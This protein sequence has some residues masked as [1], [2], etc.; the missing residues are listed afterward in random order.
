MPASVL[1]EM[2]SKEKIWEKQKNEGYKR[3]EN[4]TQEKVHVILKK[5]LRDE[6]LKISGRHY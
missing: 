4:E 6:H 2:Y 1:R 3:K 5:T